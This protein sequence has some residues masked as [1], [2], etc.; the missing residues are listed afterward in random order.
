MMGGYWVLEADA[1]AIV[2]GRPGDDA[3]RN[4]EEGGLGEVLRSYAPVGFK[5]ES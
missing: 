5:R 4:D 2:E 3:F 1:F